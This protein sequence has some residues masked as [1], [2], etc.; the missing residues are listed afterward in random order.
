MCVADALSPQWVYESNE[1]QFHLICRH[2]SVC[3]L[4]SLSLRYCWLQDKDNSIFCLIIVI[5][6]WHNGAKV[7]ILPCLSVSMPVFSPLM[8]FQTICILLQILDQLVLSSFWMVL[9]SFSLIFWQGDLSGSADRVSLSVE[10]VDM[11]ALTATL[12]CEHGCLCRMEDCVSLLILLF[13]FYSLFVSST[14]IL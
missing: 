2:F 9:L 6:W 10:G 1:S 8:S 4:L 5:A 13:S 7:K 12:R 14:Q 11:V 3:T